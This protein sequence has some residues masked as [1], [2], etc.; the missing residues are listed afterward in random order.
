ML[1]QQPTCEA[2]VQG[3]SR[4]RATP[5]RDLAFCFFHNPETAQDVAEA[6]RLGGRRRRRR[7]ETLARGLP[8]GQ[9]PFRREC[10]R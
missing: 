4:S 5:M 6:P 7:R 3:G 10:I 1:G 9:E 2:I 8:A